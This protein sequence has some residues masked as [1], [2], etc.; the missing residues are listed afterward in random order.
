LIK[1]RPRKPFKIRK[2]AQKTH[3]KGSKKD[4]RRGGSKGSNRTFLKQYF[5]G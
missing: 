2:K 4:K 5:I 3:F 1:E